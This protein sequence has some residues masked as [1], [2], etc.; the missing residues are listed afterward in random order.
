MINLEI[1]HDSLKELSDADYQTTFWLGGAAGEQ[2]SFTEAI[3]RLFDDAGL[4]RAADSGEL[5]RTFS[6]ELSIKVGQLRAL[7]KGIDDTG[8][9]VMT[10]NHPGM[11]ALRAVAKELLDLFIAESKGLAADSAVGSRRP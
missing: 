9:P 7:A 8:T 10:V 5:D 4:A 6:R 1:I 2:S 11:G 3:C